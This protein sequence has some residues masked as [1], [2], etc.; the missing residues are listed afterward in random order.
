MKEGWWLNYETGRLFRVHEHEMWL[1]E[2]GNGKR[3]GLPEALFRTALYRYKAGE[4]RDKLL[5]FIVTCF[6]V[7]RIRGHG[8]YV[9]IEHS[10]W[11]VP[12]VI[13]AIKRFGRKQGFGPMLG[14][15]IR[16]ITT[17]EGHFGL[18]R[19]FP[20]FLSESPSACAMKG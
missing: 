6:P 3:L 10:G 7:A 15:N 14:L 18:W 11:G 20:H 5:T 13:P 4:E 12:D 9:T 2:P 19:D 17:G 16:V 1:R 8:A